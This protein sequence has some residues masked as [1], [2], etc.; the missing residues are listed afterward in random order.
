[1]PG[2]GAEDAVAALVAAELA[3]ASLRDRAPRAVL[4]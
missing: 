2:A 3:G 4:A 1:M